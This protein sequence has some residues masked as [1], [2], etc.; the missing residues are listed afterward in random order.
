MP[1]SRA[2]KPDNPYRN[3]FRAPS[4]LLYPGTHAGSHQAAARSHSTAISLAVAKEIKTGW[5]EKRNRHGFWQR[6]YFLLDERALNYYHG[7]DVKPFQLRDF[8]DALAIPGKRGA[9]EIVFS[10]TAPEVFPEKRIRVRVAAGDEDEM[11]NWTDAIAAACRQLSIGAALT[12]AASP[13]S[14]APMLLTPP[15]LTPPPLAPPPLAPPP[16][17]SPPLAPPPLAPPP[18]TT[19]AAPPPTA[20]SPAAAAIPAAPAGPAGPVPF[21]EMVRRQLRRKSNVVLVDRKAEVLELLGSL[22]RTTWSKAELWPTP[23]VTPSLRVGGGKAA[24]VRVIELRLSG[25]GVSV[26]AAAPVLIW[27]EAQSQRMEERCLPL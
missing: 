13:A 23:H 10:G 8:Q 25:P 17:A 5:L 16:L 22:H 18:V 19:P 21:E 9:F 2:L 12:G 6:R 20:A 3:P 26:D 15:P 1:A 27:W 11:R 7:S 24:S 14:P 4:L